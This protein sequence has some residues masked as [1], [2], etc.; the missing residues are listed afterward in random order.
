M[1]RE[2]WLRLGGVLGFTFLVFACD[3]GD[4]ADPVAGMETGGSEAPEAETS[5]S[6][7]ME[8]EA[9]E[10]STGSE[11]T[12]G[13]EPMDC[14]VSSG[15]ITP[16]ALIDDF[17]DG[18][19]QLAATGERNG[20]W[21]V[22]S[23][24]TPEATITPMAEAFALP[25]R[26]LGGRC[27]SDYAMRITGQGFT[28]WGAVLSTTFRYDGVLV[29]YDASAYR[30]ITFWARVGELHTGG[31]RVQF[32]DSTSAPE[33]G[34]CNPEPMLPDSCFDSFGTQILPLD[35]TWRQYQLP[36]DQL[37]QRGFGFQGEAID[38]TSLYIAEWV[39]DA[40]SVFDVWIDDVW[41]YL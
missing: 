16:T 31:L 3:G 34:L 5:G 14:M 9:G 2:S 32:Q 29:S 13:G 41:F 6:T 26:I 12:D 1:N 39:V 8:A 35:T 40:N 23:D 19:A 36:F 28:D 22:S 4:D 21:W 17:E 37:A 30:G 10:A 7:G 38:I 15:P 24:G 18:N 33:G 20:A 25:E 11:T 27:E